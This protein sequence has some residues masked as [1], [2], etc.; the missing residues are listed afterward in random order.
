MNQ[1]RNVKQI[2]YR[3]RTQLREKCKGMGSAFDDD[4]WR[5]WRELN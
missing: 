4:K 2:Y 1:I 5:G 3:R